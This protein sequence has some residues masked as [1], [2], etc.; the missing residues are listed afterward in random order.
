MN[1]TG[2][3][4]DQWLSVIEKIGTALGPTEKQIRLGLIGLVACVL[5]GMAARVSRDLDA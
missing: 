1:A 4:R 3:D 5:G 2:L